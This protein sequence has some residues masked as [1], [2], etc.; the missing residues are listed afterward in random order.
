VKKKG[1][2]WVLAGRMLQQQGDTQTYARHAAAV[3]S[4]NH[5][6]LTDGA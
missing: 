2:K 3:S 1:V 4:L 5:L 6:T